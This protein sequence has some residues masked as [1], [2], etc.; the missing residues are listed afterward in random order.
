MFMHNLLL[1][2]G[3]IIYNNQHFNLGMYKFRNYFH[4]IICHEQILHFFIPNN[5]IKCV[6]F[7]YVKSMPLYVIKYY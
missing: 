2:I 4:I 1:H 3:T 7:Y 6:F 5:V